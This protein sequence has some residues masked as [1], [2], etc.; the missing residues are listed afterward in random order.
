MLDSDQRFLLPKMYWSVFENV[1]LE[2]Y[3]FG[4]LVKI[5]VATDSKPTPVCLV[6]VE[7][8]DHVDRE[9]PK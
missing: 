1:A 2:Y 7:N 3:H 8:A 9:P 5:V 6:M 4:M